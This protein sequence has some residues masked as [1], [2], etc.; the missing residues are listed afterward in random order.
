MPAHTS[1]ALLGIISLNNVLSGT[2]VVNHPRRKETQVNLFCYQ[3]CAAYIQFIWQ[4]VV[5]RTVPE[6]QSD[7]TESA[8]TSAR[9]PQ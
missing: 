4:V 2:Q 6:P 8:T 1:L 3:F 5:V 7:G 9:H